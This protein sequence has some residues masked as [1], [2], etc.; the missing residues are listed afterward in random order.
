MAGPLRTMLSMPAVASAL[1]TSPVARSRA[2]VRAASPRLGFMPG[3]LA[4]I[5]GDAGSVV[6]R[7]VVVSPL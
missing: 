1:I 4:V 3:K 7:N 5:G 6:I 2:R